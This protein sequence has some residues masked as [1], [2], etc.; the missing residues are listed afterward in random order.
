M[1]RNVVKVPAIGA[2]IQIETQY[3]CDFSKFIQIHHVKEIE[4][5]TNDDL[6]LILIDN[7]HFEMSS[8][9]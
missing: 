4:T 8:D 5:C 2:G 3:K 1:L 6:L 7:F 9:N